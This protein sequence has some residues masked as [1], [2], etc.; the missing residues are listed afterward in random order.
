MKLKKISFLLLLLVAFNTTNSYSQTI[1]NAVK[2]KV[3]THFSNTLD[4]F[5]GG[6]EVTDSW[7]NGDYLYVKGTFKYRFE[8]WLGGSDIRTRDYVAKLKQVL[9]DITVIN[10]AWEYWATGM[11][12]SSCKFTVKYDSYMCKKLKQ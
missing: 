3:Y 2:S 5:E 6:V 11:Q 10:I 12:S 9:D 1:M 8:Y 4:R 7:E